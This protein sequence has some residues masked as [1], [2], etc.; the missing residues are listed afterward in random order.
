MTYGPTSR[1]RRDT[2]T[3]FQNDIVYPSADTD[4]VTLKTNPKHRGGFTLVEALTAIVVLGIIIPVAVRGL[5]I[6]SLAGE[7]AQRK[8]VALRVADRI[9][10]ELVV[11]GQWQRTANGNAI[12]G[13][14]TYRWQLKTQAW[15]KDSLKLLSLHVFYLTR[16]QSYDVRLC[17]VVD[18]TQL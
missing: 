4:K 18:T 6:A 7:V 9:L 3:C 10:N 1:A 5:Q 15:E 16:G 17:T 2:R 8:S 14:E 12:E 11:T 13:D